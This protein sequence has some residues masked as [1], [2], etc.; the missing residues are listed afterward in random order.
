MRFILLLSLL[1]CSFGAYSQTAKTMQH[2][3]KRHQLCLDKGLRMAGCSQLFYQQMDS[4]LNVSYRQLRATLAPNAQAA[5]QKEQRQWLS[6]RDRLF[7]EKQQDLKSLA[8]DNRMIAY[9]EL[10][11]FVKARA[12]VLFR[13]WEQIKA[14]PAGKK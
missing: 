13:R 14:T 4:M 11:A 7:L 9:E 8:Q 12:L 1:L 5:L 2:L 10:A 6:Q 3:E